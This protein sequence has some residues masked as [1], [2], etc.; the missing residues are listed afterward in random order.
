MALT[1]M[2]KNR[3]SGLGRGLDAIFLDNAGEEPKSG[4]TMLRVSEIEPRPDQPRKNFEPEA[5]AALA[6]SIA[7]NGVLQPLLVRSGEDGFYQIIAGE[8]RWRASKMAGLTEVPVIITE[9]DDKKAF[10]LALIENIQRENLNAIEEAAAIRD[11]MTE[12]G[13]THEEVSVRISRSRSAVSNA[14]RLLDL[15]DSVMKM[16]AD[17]QLSSGHARALLGLKNRDDIVRAAET[18]IEREMSVRS[19]EEYVRST[20][21]AAECDAENSGKTETDN[22]VLPQVRYMKYLE[23]KICESFGHGVKIINT[24]KRKKIEIEYTDNDDFEKIIK[25]MCGEYFFDEIEKVPEQSG[26]V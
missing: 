18:V 13:L 26:N 8:R 14:I 15:P 19:T 5:I 12:Y 24:P 4:V 25:K 2:A 23:N 17:G 6:D 21:R 11:L 22:S 16:V 3:N 7:E 10:E 9:A 1:T 20:N